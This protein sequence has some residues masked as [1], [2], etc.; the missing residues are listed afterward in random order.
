[1]KTYR[2]LAPYYDRF[3][4]FIDYETEAEDIYRFLFQQQKTNGRVLDIGAGSG[5]HM[6]P[7][8]RMGVKVDGLD[9][10]ENMLDILKTKIKTEGFNARLFLDD[11]RSFQTDTLYDMV[12]CFGDTVHH[13]ADTREIADF[14]RCAFRS[15]KA[16]GT[17]L[18]SWQE[19]GYFTELAEC[20]EFYECHGDEYLLWHAKVLNDEA[21]AIA[22]T[23]FIKSEEEDDVYRRFR[24]NHR[25]SIFDFD[26]IIKTA[27]NNGFIVRPD[28]ETFCFGEL[29]AE[30][31]YKHI[32]ILEKVN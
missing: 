5:G 11:M 32:T 26:Q 3:M 17:L 6:I 9:Y 31:P 13:L 25:L 28:L 23:A 24:E 21:A 1:M 14:L 22:Y 4:S 18:F 7:L 20:G 2:E 30:E 8:L 15:L 10:A 29:L 27:Q 16:G 12:Y 19:K